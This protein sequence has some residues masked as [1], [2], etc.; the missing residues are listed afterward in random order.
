MT[1][2]DYLRAVE[3]V[4]K[5]AYDNLGNSSVA[6]GAFVKLFLGDNPRFDESRFHSACT[7]AVQFQRDLKNQDS[8][9]K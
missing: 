8:K 9:K 1:K 6:E 3:I 2:K 7:K 5:L 4:G